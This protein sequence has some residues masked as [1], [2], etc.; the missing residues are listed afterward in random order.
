MNDSAREE[1][2]WW[3]RWLRS[4]G[5]EVMT[6]GEADESGIADRLL[7]AHRAGALVRIAR[8]AY[9]PASA[10]DAPTEPERRA[11]RY[12]LQ[13]LAAAKQ[14]ENPT[15]TGYSALAILR[16]PIIDRW[17]DDI[18]LQGHR[19]NGNRRPGVITVS[20][21]C[22]IPT[23]VVDGVR[24]VTPESALIQ[25]ARSSPLLPVLVAANA[26]CFVPRFGEQV[27]LSTP[28]GLRA[29][30]DRL[31]PYRGCRRVSH[32]LC[33]VNTRSESALETISDVAID[34]LGFKAPTKQATITLPS[35]RTVH[36]DYLWEEEGIGGE[37]DGD[38]K[39]RGPRTAEGLIEEKRREDEL[40][41]QLRGLVRW[42]WQAAWHRAP[43]ER[44]LA[45]A[46][47]PRI[48]RSRML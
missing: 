26:A 30:H 11:A 17:P 4:L 32:M 27:P 48:R 47:V 37:A 28:E 6:Y 31:M 38:R 42:D 34:A 33:R 29:E 24:I 46:G 40:R 18:I 14:H 10:L 13:V 5:Q 23:R 1:M 45:R 25:A 44:K 20:R 22:E 12:R 3:A 9:V 7:R 43:L 16:L 39:Y 21:R 35:G 8:G 41:E 19:S 2:Q 15:F 36:L